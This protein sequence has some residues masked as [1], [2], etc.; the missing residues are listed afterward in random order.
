M[1]PV[2]CADL[3]VKRQISGLPNAISN[4]QKK[5]WQEPGVRIVFH[6]AHK[7]I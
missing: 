3:Y 7:E 5:E 2:R 6:R 1:D 4:K